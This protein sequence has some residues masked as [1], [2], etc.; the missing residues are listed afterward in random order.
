MN[1][2]EAV[3]M[4]GQGSKAMDPVKTGQYGLGFSSVY[5]LTD[6]PCILT[7]GPEVGRTLCVFD[8]LRSHVPGATVA[9][10]GKR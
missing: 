8:P 7:A 3:Q 2:L 4:F 10:P 5:H 1:D 9:E 6:V